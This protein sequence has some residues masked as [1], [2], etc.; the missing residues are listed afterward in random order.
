MKKVII[1][2][3]VVTIVI[4]LYAFFF[5]RTPYSIGGV[6][7]GYNIPKGLTVE[8]FKDEW[9]PNGDGESLIIFNVRPEQEQELENKC[10][11]KKYDPLPIKKDLP[12][13]LI[14]NYLG[15]SDSLGYYTL[16]IEKKDK[17]N[18]SIVIFNLKKHRL[19]VYNVIN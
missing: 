4:L 7:A 2:V 13:N 16:N 5:R 9:N 12:D 6:I 15:K 17:R 8:Q 19:I 14:Y 18:Y 11:E 3:I 10:I 1:I